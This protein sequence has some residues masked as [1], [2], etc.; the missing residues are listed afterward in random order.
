MKIGILKPEEAARRAL[1]NVAKFKADQAKKALEAKRKPRK[2]KP[3]SVPAV[4]EKK[5]PA[6][7]K[8]EELNKMLWSKAAEGRVRDVER[9]LKAG[10]DVNSHWSDHGETALMYAAENG[11][12]ELAEMLIEYGA[13]VNINTFR[14]A[15]AWAARQ[16][17]KDVVELLIANG[18]DVNAKA[19]DKQTVLT[20]AWNA[21]GP[22]KTLR[23]IVRI[24]EDHGAK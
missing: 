7:E 3:V 4:E 17:H 16:G 20:E 8:K 14:S 5:G 24:L 9:L 13:D 11:H 12:M 19:R 18:A 2:K 15:L 10:A 21:R 23:E 22:E 1:A 6:Q